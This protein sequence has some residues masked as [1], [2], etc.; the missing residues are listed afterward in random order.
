MQLPA[1][2][3]A[4]PWELRL[5]TFRLHAADTLRG[6]ARPHVG[7]DMRHGASQRHH[8]LDFGPLPF[9]TATPTHPPTHPALTRCGEVGHARAQTNTIAAAATTTAMG[10]RARAR[11]A[12]SAA[13]QRARRRATG[14]L[15]RV[16]SHRA[17]EPEGAELEGRRARSV[18]PESAEPESAGPEGAKPEGRRARGPLED[19]RTPTTNPHA[20]IHTHTHTARKAAHP[21]L[22]AA[23]SCI[24]PKKRAQKV[25]IWLAV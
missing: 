21:R 17:A 9:S 23:S 4:R 19:T 13:H 24:P 25:Q 1:V 8:H 12:Q 14:P 5:H 3:E 22:F 18:E 7:D 20:H 15:T 16:P 10:S 2:F 11:R 6:P